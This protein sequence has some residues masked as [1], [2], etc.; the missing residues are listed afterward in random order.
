MVKI[1]LKRIGSKYKPFY[2]VVAADAR[3][4]RDGRF[5]EVLGYYNPQNKEIKLEK[6]LVLKWLEY[7]AVPTDTTRRLLKKESLLE[8]FAKNKLQKVG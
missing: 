7:G 2:K 4:P 1:R 8:T 6:N 3:A 5:I